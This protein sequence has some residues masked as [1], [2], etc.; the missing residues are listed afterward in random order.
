MWKAAS[1]FKADESVKDDANDGAM[2]T[3]ETDALTTEEADHSK[4]FI[5]IP[6]VKGIIDNLDLCKAL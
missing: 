4:K 2:E 1:V 3:V 5:C 6:N